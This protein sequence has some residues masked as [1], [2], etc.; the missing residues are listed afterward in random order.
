MLL[1]CPW[2]LCHMGDQ[3]GYH[4]QTLGYDGFFPMDPSFYFA[5]RTTQPCC[6]RPLD[7]SN[8]NTRCKMINR[9][10]SGSETSTLVNS[11]HER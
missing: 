6:L 8:S 2:A 3:W 7:H 4:Q 11:L 10:K 5:K 1:A 9:D